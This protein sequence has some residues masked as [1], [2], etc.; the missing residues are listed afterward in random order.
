MFIVIVRF[1]YDISARGYV[2]CT[3]EI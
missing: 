1:F 2:F 3:P